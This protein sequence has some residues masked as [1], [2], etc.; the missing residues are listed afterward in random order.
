MVSMDKEETRMT[1]IRLVA[2]KWREL[3][4][5]RGEENKAHF[6][7]K[8]SATPLY[9]SR[10]KCLGVGMRSPLSSLCKLVETARKEVIVESFLFTQD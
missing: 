8:E 2:L 9:A 6:L 10:N 3:E 7:C 1:W 4:M 5:M